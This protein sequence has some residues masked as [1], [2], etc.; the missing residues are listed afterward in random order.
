MPRYG[1]GNEVWPP[2]NEG[3]VKLADS[4]PKG[5]IPPEVTRSLQ[6]I[7]DETEVPPVE[8]RRKIPRAI[9]RILRRAAR[10]QEKS[11]EET[12]DKT[13]AVIALALLFKGYVRPLEVLLVAFLSGYLVLLHRWSQSVR[14]D[15]ITPLLPALPPQGHVPSLVTN[16]LGYDMAYSSL[17]DRWLK[18]GVWIGLLGPL[19]LTARWTAAGDVHRAQAL[20]RPLFLLC[21]QALAEAS[22][23]R[24]ALPIRILI[25]VAFNTIRLGYLWQ[26]MFVTSSDRWLAVAN[27][28]YWS[29]NLFGF[30]LP[31]GVIKYMRA[32]FWAVEARVVETRS[33]MADGVGL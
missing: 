22:S 15:G 1:R 29:L 32:H 24:N 10:S 23:R 21:C 11:N 7:G 31:I 18:L 25:P 14:D 6:Q 20:A 28:V 19:A 30:L 9:H 27:L 13:P 12:M 2:T 3:P 16:P 5:E 8:W 26:W 33:N 4:F 17:Y